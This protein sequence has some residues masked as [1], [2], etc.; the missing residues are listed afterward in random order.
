M[1]PIIVS[2]AEIATASGD[3]WLGCLG[4]GSCVSVC[5]YDPQA[6]VA[7]MAYI[8]FPDGIE[9][10]GA[11]KPAKYAESGVANLIASMESQGANASRIRAALAGGAQMMGGDALSGLFAIGART[12]ETV[13]ANL[14]NRGITVVASDVGGRE[15]RTVTIHARSGKVVVR[16]FGE[17]ERELCDLRQAQAGG[18]N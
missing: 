10:N 17:G 4:L 12:V 2:V 11:E 13:Q 8:M 5:A 6:S 18:A 14:I 16:S 9:R 15:G 3:Q 7:G 1:E